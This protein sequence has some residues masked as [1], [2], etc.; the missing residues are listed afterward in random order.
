MLIVVV[1]LCGL[2]TP[3][4]A[5]EGPT[6]AGPIGGTDIRSA[7]LP[8]PGLYGGSFLLGAGTRE[9]LDGEG[10]VIP[11]L[12]DAHLAKQLAGPF[13]FYVPDFRVLGGSIGFGG[14]IPIG[15]QCGHLFTGEPRRCTADLG[16]PYVE[17]DWSRSFGTLRP[18]KFP[19]AHPVLE[20]LT[21]LIGFGVVIPAGGFDAS[22]PTEQA[23]S[24]GNNTWDFAPAIAFTY[25]T[26]P[27]LAEGTEVSA[28]LFWNNYLENSETHY[29]AGD[30]LNLDFAVSERIGRFQIG[31]TGFYAFQ[32]ED[33]KQFGVKVEPDGRRAISSTWAGSWAT[34]C[35]R[36]PLQ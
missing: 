22:A 23:L 30:V 25:T 31:F 35:R 7:E 10:R 8:P 15:N 28:K 17:I 20:G 5:V 6:A 26:P 11:A 27:I 16:D 13:L 33:D 32:I 29:R 12:K 4:P 21:I 18:S 9:F 3:V 14:M 36:M 2:P 19:G 34:T 24:I 1:F